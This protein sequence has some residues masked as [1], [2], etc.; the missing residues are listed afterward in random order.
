MDPER[1]GYDGEVGANTNA[2]GLGERSRFP[3]P[4]CGDA[5]PMRVM[6]GFGYK[7]VDEWHAPA[8]QL[9]RPQDFFEAFWLYGSCTRCQNVVSILGF[10]CA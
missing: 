9:Q 6:P 8:E 10:E 2:I 7:D 1:D 4:R 3:C 5:T